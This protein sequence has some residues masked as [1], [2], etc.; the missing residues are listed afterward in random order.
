MKKISVVVGVWN[1]E[2]FIESCLKSISNQ[3]IPRQDYEIIV[4]DGGSKDNTVKI[5]KKYA[6]VVLEGGY[7]PVG[8]ARQ[9][10]LKKAGGK[11]VAFTDGDGTVPREWLETM[12]KAFEEQGIIC[13]TGPIEC[14]EKEVPLSIEQAVWIWMKTAKLFTLLNIAGAIGSNFAVDKKSFMKIGG[15]R[16]IKLED[17]DASFRLAKIGKLKYLDNIPVKTSVRRFERWGVIKTMSIGLLANL[18][19]F[20]GMTPST[21]WEK[22]D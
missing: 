10:G 7:K 4:A 11:I 16:K 12:V 21:D 3:T 2:K 13:V 18:Q 20:L 19:V 14:L 8:A 22:V 6:D 1:E 17:T 9:A 15:F 5:A